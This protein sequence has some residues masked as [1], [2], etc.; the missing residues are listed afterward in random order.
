MGAPAAAPPAGIPVTALE[1]PPEVREQMGRLP[2]RPAPQEQVAAGKGLARTMQVPVMRRGH[3]ET[4]PIGDDSIAKAVAALPFAGS[5]VGT[6][7]C[8]SRG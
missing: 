4:V 8:R 7:R 6:G 1:L 2:F 5:T 3:G